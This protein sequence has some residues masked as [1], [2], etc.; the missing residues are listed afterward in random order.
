MVMRNQYYLGIDLSTQ[1]LTAV[2]IELSSR[3]VIRHSIDFDEG[4]PSYGTSSGVVAGEDALVVHADPRMWLEALDDMCAWLR[5][6]HL[7]DNIRG[8]GVSAQQHGTVY[9]KAGAHDALAAADP[10]RPL[11]AQLETIFSRSTSPVW[12]DASTHRECGEITAALG[13]DEQVAALTGSIATE[14]FAAAQIRKFWREHP[15]GY[16]K[17]AHIHLI[18][19]FVTS[20]FSGIPAPVDDGDGFGTNLADI[21]SGAW[22]KAAAA[23]AAPGLLDR[24]PRLETGN[25]VVGRVSAYFAERYGFGRDTMVVIGSGDNPCSLTGLGLLGETDVYAISLGTSD[26]CFGYMPELPNTPR[27]SGHV[28]GT[29]D[30]RYMFLICFKNGGL[31]RERVKDRFALS[32][33][34]FADILSQSPTGN[35]GRIILPYFLSEITPLVLETGVRRFGGLQE[36]DLDG[37]VRGVVEA[38]II[39]MYL[40][41]S[42]TGRRPERIV[43]TAGGSE[44]KELLRIISQVFGTVVNTFTLKDSAAL[45]AALKAAQGCLAARGMKKK[46]RDLTGRFITAENVLV[47]RPDPSAVRVYRQPGG[48]IDVYAACE[49]FVLGNGPDPAEQ[50]RAFRKTFCIC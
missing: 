33:Q 47:V 17:T 26:T 10:G 44:N 1:S 4:Y 19:S 34:E 32:W 14:R 36:S 9:L 41:S 21:R 22:S 31:A 43:V 25:P 20:V 30:G 18:S 28:F 42:W 40:H 46:W 2:V 37:N 49:N 29:A 7:A 16:E 24:L 12:M 50:I 35:Q 38:Q 48:L 23:A 3:E 45:G 39:S 27:T 6:R 8:I 15:S 11:Q 5:E 13:G